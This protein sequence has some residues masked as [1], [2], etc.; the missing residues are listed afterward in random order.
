MNTRLHW[1]LD[2]VV[3][4]ELNLSTIGQI[5]GFAETAVVESVPVVE[6]TIVCEDKEEY[7]QWWASLGACYAWQSDM[8]K[9]CP[10]TCIFCSQG[11]PPRTPL[12]FGI[13]L[14]PTSLLS[15]PPTLV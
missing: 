8:M 1:T 2:F 5:F 4:E 14:Q 15:G 9:S 13:W 6:A 11:M 12:F 10:Q 3:F 7:C